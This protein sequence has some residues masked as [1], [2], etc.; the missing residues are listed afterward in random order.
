MANTVH[1]T[2]FVKRMRTQGGTTYCFNSSIEDI[3]L[4]V[5]ERNNIVK[6]SHY[7]LLNIPSID[8][9]DASI[10]NKF[11][12]FAISGAFQSFLNSGSVKDGRVV[13][14]ESFQNYALNLECNLLDLS[15][16][17]AELPTTVSERVFWKW[18]KETG[19][20][21]WT[22]SSIANGINYWKEEIDGS[23]GSIVKAVGEISA[24][25]VRNGTFGTYNETYILVPTSFGKTKVFFKQVEDDNYKHGMKIPT[26][27]SGN[28]RIL[29]RE[30]Y[31]KPHPDGFDFNA[32]YDMADSSSLT[33]TYA[34]TYDNNVTMA[35]GWWYTYEGI[36][37]PART[38]CTDISTSYNF[39]LNN[40]NT[41]LKYD[42]GGGTT[43]E[44]LRS[45][46]DCLS[47]ELDLDH[48][49]TLYDDSAITFDKMAIERAEATSY[50][51]NTVLLYYSVKNKSNDTVLATNLLGV[52]FLDPPSGNTSGF[53]INEIT[54]PSIT[55]LQSG[56]TGFGTS[57]SFRLNIKSDYM[58][59]DTL[60]IVTDSTA[61]QVVLEDFAQVFDGLSQSLTILNQ[62]TGTINYITEQY[63][64]ISS[65][66]T[67]IVNDIADLQ[68]QVN[69]LS[70]DIVGTE[71]T[72]PMFIAGDDPLGD[73]SIFMYQGKIGVF[74][75]KP[76][77]PIQLDASVK[78]KDI[79]LETAIR[80]LSNN[81]LLSYGSP[82]QL[83]S[84]TN[85]REISM[86]TGNN[87]PAINI[88]VSNRVLINGF[89]FSNIDAAPG[90]LRG[91][92]IRDTSL[93]A[94]LKWS[95][96]L[97]YVD[98]STVA[99]GVTAAYVDGSL[100][101][102]IDIATANASFGIYNASTNNAFLTNASLGKVS[103]LTYALNAS[104][105]AYTTN[106]SI[107][108][109]LALYTK[110]VSLS[111]DF[112][113]N[114]G[115]LEVSLG[116]VINTADFATN[117]SVGLAFL[118][119]SSLGVL[120]TKVNYLDA[121]LGIT[122]KLAF[123]NNSSI[124]WLKLYIDGSLT[125]L[126]ASIGI[127]NF[128]TNASVNNAF[129]T[130]AS[131]GNISGRVATLDISIK[132]YATNAS[133]GTANFT[134]NASVA[135][136]FLTNVSLGNISGRVET[137]D[138]SIKNYATNASVNLAFGAYA[139]NTS[140]NSAFLTNASLGKVLD[141][142]LGSLSDNDYLRYDASI[143]KWVN[144]ATED[145][146]LYFYSKT[147]IDASFALK[148]KYAFQNLIINAS[149]VS[150]TIANGYNAKVTLTSDA[151]LIITDASNGYSGTLIVI[152]DP[153]GSRLLD[154]PLGSYKNNDWILSTDASA[155]DIIS[156]LYDGI[157][158]YWK[159][160]GSYA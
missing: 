125:T 59:D 25:A 140:V 112:L 159:K 100:N 7:A 47:I 38:Y 104:I 108:G 42:N 28:S 132:N 43:I 20:I 15:T 137:L 18:L 117:A 6:M 79:Y 39:G 66:H 21:R 151:S 75:N 74:N 154:L 144:E 91:L 131:L 114:N 33:G 48:L 53:P 3:G 8:A 87:I 123:V 70:R 157:N 46:V 36:N 62:H 86:Y 109:T 14:A 121:S 134:T 45:K 129:L 26:T 4:N 68:Y 41:F 73:S 9:P 10:Q 145:V 56:A 105:G 44:F 78:T 120:T 98:V 116:S 90:T 80:D 82:L 135:S 111:N 57:Y 60:S 106:S 110:N 54:L 141:I 94:G 142:S 50:D 153:S 88:D 32:Y 133:V 107:S 126:N 27:G 136:A 77:Y 34:M 71:N 130:N 2:P 149:T 65:T 63:L 93:G 143:G 99:G 127:A 76:T 81:V 102:K 23:Y 12:A 101:L 89:L 85:Y 51:F 150:W 83:G 13:I 92:P 113:W 103:V 69:D 19:A 58:L 122:S 148:P 160:D 64:D 40:Y 155:R 119:N 61:S 29:G 52:L 97:F 16:Y 17:N 11:N 1:T 138:I 49:K 124:G 55:K 37:P 35:P 147:E 30:S 24:G 139:T 31:M 84:S 72:I 152:Q 96:G 95:S 5:N 118:T 22:D 158:Y 146:S 115:Y 67:D 128:A 156:F